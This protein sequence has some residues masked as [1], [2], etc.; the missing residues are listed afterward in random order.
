VKCWYSGGF[1]PENPLPLRLPQ[2]ASSIAAAPALPAP[3]PGNSSLDTKRSSS[4][5][6]RDDW[7]GT[8]L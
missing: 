8:Q 7:E 2:E 5:G 4:V 3:R 1:C 6:D